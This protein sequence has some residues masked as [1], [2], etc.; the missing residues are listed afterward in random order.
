[1]KAGRVRWHDVKDARV[2][3]LAEGAL[4]AIRIKGRDVCFVRLNGVLRAMLDVCPHQG[5]PLSGGWCDAGHVVCPWHRF[6]LDPLTGASKFG[7]SDPVQVFPVEEHQQRVRIG[8][9]GGFWDFLKK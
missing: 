6:Y 1:M 4:L 7:T 2:A 8:M 9:P 3:G 5:R